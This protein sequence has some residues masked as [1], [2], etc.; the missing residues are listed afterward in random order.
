MA[1]SLSTYAVIDIESTIFAKGNPFSYRNKLCLAGVRT[2]ALNEIIQVEYDSTLP[3]AE[4]ITRLKYLVGSVDTLVLFNAKFDL[5]WLARYGIT[6]P[7]SVRIFDCQLA[8]FILGDQR[9]AYPSLDYCLAKYNLGAK[10]DIVERDYWSRGID[11]PEVPLEILTE[12][13][14]EDLRL[15]DELYQ[16][17]LRELAGAAKSKARLIR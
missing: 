1:Q 5:N 11:T 7:Y 12:Y 2:N 6:V 4:A 3:Y 13:L 14:N 15:T 9:P 17:Q 16:R 8:E 10:L